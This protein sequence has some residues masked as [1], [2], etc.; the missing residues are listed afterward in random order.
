MQAYLLIS[1]RERDERTVLENLRALEEIQEAHV[2][3]GECG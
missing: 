2:L 1:L 3:F